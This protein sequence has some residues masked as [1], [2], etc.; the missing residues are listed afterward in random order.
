MIRFDDHSKLKEAETFGIDGTLVD[1][2][3]VKSRNNKAGQS[4]TLVFDQNTGFD[5]DLSLLVLLKQHKRVNGAG[6]YL[7]IDDLDEVKFSQKEFKDKLKENEMLRNK[8][9]EVS[10]DILTEFIYKDQPTQTEAE[11]DSNVSDLILS[12]M[13]A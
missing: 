11:N 6:R 1:L 3:L 13:A 4:V 10:L 2:T 12:R 8:L 9:V 7:Y 5:E